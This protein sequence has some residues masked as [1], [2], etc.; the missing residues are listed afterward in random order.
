MKSNLCVCKEAISITTTEEE[1][2]PPGSM[3]STYA[4][5]GEY[6]QQAIPFLSTALIN[7]LK[8]GSVLIR[9]DSHPVKLKISC[10]SLSFRK[11]FFP[12]VTNDKW[13]DWKW[14]LQNRITNLDELQGIIHLS[15]DEKESFIHPK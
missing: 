10:Q 5:G 1:T 13:N 3:P 15:K 9:L 12:K 7:S 14:Q 4:N 8:T 2:E 6:N 11:R